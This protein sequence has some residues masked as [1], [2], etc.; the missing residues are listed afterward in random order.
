M[1]P[2]NRVRS[3]KIPK[4]KISWLKWLE[5][6]PDTSKVEGSSPSEITMKVNCETKIDKQSMNHKKTKTIS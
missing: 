2:E 1:E 3:P 5:H 4:Y 6:R